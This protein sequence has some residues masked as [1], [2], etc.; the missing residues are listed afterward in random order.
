MSFRLPQE[1]EQREEGKEGAKRK[2]QEQEED[3]MYSVRSVVETFH[4]EEIARQ[5]VYP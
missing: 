2:N 4:L 5:Q 1:G 3:R